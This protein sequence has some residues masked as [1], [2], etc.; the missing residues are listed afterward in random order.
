MYPPSPLAS[1]PTLQ[2]TF[3]FRGPPTC[4]NAMNGSRCTENENQTRATKI[5]I[6]FSSQVLFFFASSFFG[7][8]KM[9]GHVSVSSYTEDTYTNTFH[10]LELQYMESTEM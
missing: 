9:Q 1:S 5:Y 2:P 4:Y 8:E 6:F 7:K 10:E 3:Q